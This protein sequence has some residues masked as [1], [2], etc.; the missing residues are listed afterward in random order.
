VVLDSS[1]GRVSGA[2][3]LLGDRESSVATTD[4]HTPIAQLPRQVTASASAHGAAPADAPVSASTVLSRH[5]TI[6]AP[7]AQTQL[8]EC[9]HIPFRGNTDLG[10][11]LAQ[12]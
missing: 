1:G 12:P 5:P 3:V 10:I 11:C 8:P 2:V 4:G 6:L 7:V 9:R